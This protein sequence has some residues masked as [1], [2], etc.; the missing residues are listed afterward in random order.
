[1]PFEETIAYRYGGIPQDTPC[2]DDFDVR[3]QEQVLPRMPK[4]PPTCIIR[5]M[6]SGLSG[7]A[8]AQNANIPVIV[9]NG[10]KPNNKSQQVLYLG[11][12]IHEL[13]HIN[14]HWNWLQQLSTG[15]E[16]SANFGFHFNESAYGREFIDLIGFVETSPHKWSIPSNSVYKDIYRSNPLELSAELCAMYLLDA[17][18]E[19]STYEYQRYGNA[20]TPTILPQ[21]RNIDVD[22]YLTPEV[23][24]WLETY[25][26]LP[27][28]S[29]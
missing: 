10:T 17:I 29:E 19:P 21:R 13:C 7:R 11:V 12:E 5:T 27:D 9:I 16:N 18:G 4:Y 20:H 8:Y 14:Q 2:T 6:K 15:R 1:M 28:V 3:V 24:E 26:I 22:V 25:M 23:R